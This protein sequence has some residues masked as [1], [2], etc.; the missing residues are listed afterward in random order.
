MLRRWE[1]AFPEEGAKAPLLVAYE[2]AYLPR[3]KLRSA[4][5]E[6]EEAAGEL[7]RISS[8]SAAA[9]PARGRRA[10]APAWRD[11]LLTAAFVWLAGI[12]LLLL[13][14]TARLAAHQVRRWDWASEHVLQAGDLI[15][16]NNTTYWQILLRWNIRM[17]VLVE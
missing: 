13:I 4:G 5:S 14:A 7:W 3:Q 11:V 6:E 10:A 12:G 16:E 2:R 15:C 1:P 9:A 17:V 8:S